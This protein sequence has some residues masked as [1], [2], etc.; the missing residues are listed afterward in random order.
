MTASKQSLKVAFNSAAALRT[1]RESTGLTQ[2]AFARL[3]RV[4]QA[5]LSKYESGAHSMTMR[6]LGEIAERAGA[7]ISVTLV[8][9]S[10]NTF[11]G[12]T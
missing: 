3:V 12:P 4:S 11:K 1:L 8:P 2:T 6:R 5:D 7:D 10:K 9:K